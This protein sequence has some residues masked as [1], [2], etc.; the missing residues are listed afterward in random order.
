MNTR[1]TGKVRFVMYVSDD[2]YIW[3][4]LI[5]RY[6]VVVFLCALCLSSLAFLLCLHSIE[7]IPSILQYLH[8]FDLNLMCF[9]ETVK[10]TVQILFKNGWNLWI[11]CMHRMLEN[12]RNKWI[13]QKARTKQKHTKLGVLN[14]LFNQIMTYYCSSCALQSSCASFVL[15]LYYGERVRPLS[16]VLIAYSSIDSCIIMN[17]F[18]AQWHVNQTKAE[19]KNNNSHTHRN[20]CQVCE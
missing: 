2:V 11:Q 17:R 9:I 10:Y 8:T 18:I 19:N 12:I 16:I 1:L 20:V 3:I 6:F 14:F 13:K 15:F 4:L 5:F 7:S